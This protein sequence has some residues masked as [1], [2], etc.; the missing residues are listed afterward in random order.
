MGL[1]DCGMPSMVIV[2]KMSRKALVLALAAQGFISSLSGV[3]ERILRVFHDPKARRTSP[4][5]NRT[6]NAPCM[7]CTIE[8]MS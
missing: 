2:K 6:K 5:K 1:T 3:E 8:N 4:S 7:H